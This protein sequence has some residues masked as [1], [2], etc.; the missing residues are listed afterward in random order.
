MSGVDYA[1]NAQYIANPGVPARYDI[2]G[3]DPRGIGQSSPI[4]CLSNAEQ[5]ASLTSDPKTDNQAQY[6]QSLEDTRLN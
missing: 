2:V 5:E 1:L 4:T 3:F 6:V